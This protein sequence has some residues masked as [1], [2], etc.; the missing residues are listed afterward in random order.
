MA[1]S[2]EATEIILCMSKKPSVT[3]PLANKHPLPPTHLWRWQ[4]SGPRWQKHFPQIF[5]EKSIA[6]GG[7]LDNVSGKAE[8]NGI[9][10]G[11]GATHMGN[12]DP[13]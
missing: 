3:H 12:P 7:F 11:A 5:K 9:R 6:G 4:T 8:E 2:M 1:Q 13:R 10:V